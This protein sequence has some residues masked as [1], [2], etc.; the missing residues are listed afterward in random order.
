MHVGNVGLKSWEAYKFEKWALD[1]RESRRSLRLCMVL[2][3]SVTH[4]HMPWI[5]L[6]IVKSVTDKRQ[7]H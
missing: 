3:L 5:E 6:E 7:I 1:S 2:R 4:E